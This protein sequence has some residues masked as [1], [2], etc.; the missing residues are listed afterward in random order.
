[1]ADTRLNA[2][3]QRQAYWQRQAA[4]TAAAT[5]TK[6]TTLRGADADRVAQLLVQAATPKI[7]AACVQQ[8]GGMSTN[9]VIA[10]AASILVVAVA[11][12]AVYTTAFRRAGTA[13]RIAVAAAGVLHAGM[14]AYNRRIMSRVRAAA[15]QDPR[16][17]KP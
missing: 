10:D 13:G 2:S 5:L 16:T 6:H 3:E 15:E 14:V 8:L 7:R 9:Q 17:V 1:M 12:L 4:E 11:D